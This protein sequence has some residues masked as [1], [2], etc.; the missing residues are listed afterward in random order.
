MN[1]T[2]WK[3]R[4]RKPATALLLPVSL[5]LS[6]ENVATLRY[7]GRDWLAD[8]LAAHCPPPDVLAPLMKEVNKKA[9]ADIERDR[10][11]AANAALRR[12]GETPCP[13]AK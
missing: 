7:Y 4:P 11:G 10:R 12:R 6:R 5:R 13:T 9:K 2:A 8:L 1:E 3:G